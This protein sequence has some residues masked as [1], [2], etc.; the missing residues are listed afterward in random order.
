MPSPSVR[1]ASSRV[2]SSRNY[3]SRKLNDPFSRRTSSI[4]CESCGL[5][6]FHE[7]YVFGDTFASLISRTDSNCPGFMSNPVVQQ[8]HQSPHHRRLPQTLEGLV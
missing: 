1:S 3:C 6:N 2:W 8:V 4:S 5:R 7:G